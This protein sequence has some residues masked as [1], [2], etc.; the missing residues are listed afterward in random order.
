MCRKKYRKDRKDAT[1]RAYW[2]LF[3]IRGSHQTAFPKCLKN[4]RK[5]GFLLCFNDL[6]WPFFLH[7]Y[8]LFNTKCVKF[9]AKVPK[10][11]KD[12]LPL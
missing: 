8:T 12:F 7:I 1:Q 9:R 2:R 11:P 5:G 4:K 10:V 6:K 3:I